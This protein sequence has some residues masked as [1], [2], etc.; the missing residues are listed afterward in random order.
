MRINSKFGTI[1]YLMASREAHML[2]KDI[3]LSLIGVSNA[4]TVLGS[5]F[6]REAW[7]CRPAL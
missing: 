2:I 6:A 4:A 3:L 1:S 5:D 7:I